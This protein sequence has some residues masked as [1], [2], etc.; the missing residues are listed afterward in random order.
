[1]EEPLSL[2]PAHKI[3]K[4]TQ[5]FLPCNWFS[6]V[7][8]KDLSGIFEG[9]LCIVK[10]T[11]FLNIFALLILWHLEP[12]SWR[13]CPSQ[14]QLISKGS[15]WLSQECSCDIQTNQPRDHTYIISFIKL[16][17]NKPVFL[18]PSISPE[19]GL[20][21]PETTHTAQSLLKSFKLS[22]PKFMIIPS[23]S[24]PS[25]LGKTPQKLWGW[26]EEGLGSSCVWL[27][28]GNSSH[29]ISSTP[30]PV[31]HLPIRPPRIS[32]PH[33]FFLWASL[34]ITFIFNSS[35]RAGPCCCVWVSAQGPMASQLT[36]AEQLPHSLTDTTQIS[37]LVPPWGWESL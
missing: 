24:G 15:E 29:D 17:Q 30:D 6:S 32:I 36:P 26:S 35:L 27:H 19:P 12:W 11:I 2:C 7:S 1:M 37:A 23:L 5:N 3:L 18:L 9:W 31:S 4:S 34:I 33:F 8:F 21:H 25:F 13:D 14:G 20:K 22:H 28:F 16:T 10:W